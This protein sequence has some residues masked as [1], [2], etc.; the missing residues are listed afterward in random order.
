VVISPA[1]S[2]LKDSIA[3]GIDPLSLE[4]AGP[5]HQI[6][7]NPTETRAAIVTCGGLCPGLN[8]VIR[9]LTMS[10]HHHYG[11]KQVFGI[12]YGYR[13]MVEGETGPPILLQPDLVERISNEGGTILGSSRG[14]QNPVDMVDFLQ[15]RSIRILFTIGGD[16]TQR[17]AMAI[18]QEAQNRNYQLAVIGVPKTI[19][20]DI[21]LVEKTFGFETAVSSATEVL[22]RAHVESKGEQNGLVIVK[23][24]GRQS[25]FLATYASIASGDVNFLLI[26]EIPFEL[27]G[28]NG[29]FAHVR[30]RLLNR[31]HALMV[32]AEG[33]AETLLS[34]P[35]EKARSDASGNQ[36]YEDVGIYLRDRF[37]DHFKE[38]GFKGQVRYIDPSY[39]V[40]SL[41]VTAGDSIFC[42]N[43]SHHAVHA[44]M[45]GRTQM[46]IATCHRI[47][48]HIPLD[49]V[50]VGRQFVD[51][52]GPLW[53]SALQTTGQ[54]VNMLK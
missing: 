12:R 3:A 48:C 37:K 51:P 7:F 34:Q 49:A 14:N 28:E 16:G 32:V 52:H 29:L 27:E 23:L 53:L 42:Q 25:G 20:N 39:T 10:L 4:M 44:A 36:I 11:V 21:P 6:F 22:S 9:G 18:A 15:R 54:P 50:V 26:P 24:M 47:F 17:G 46:I 41:P 35:G 40:R 33:C 43:L 30:Q 1:L 38:T 19:D 8:D 31:G 45:S 5:R 13:G 2:D